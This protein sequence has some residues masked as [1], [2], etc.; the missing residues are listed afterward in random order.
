VYKSSLYSFNASIGGL[1]FQ[2]ASAD[3]AAFTSNVTLLGTGITQVI[4]G[5][6]GIKYYRCIA[7]LACNG[8]TGISNPI[9]ITLNAPLAC[10]CTPP[11]VYGCSDGDVISQVNL[12]TLDNNSGIS[13]PSDPV[14][15]LQGNGQDGNG[16]SDYTG[17]G[18]LTNLQAGT[19]NA[20]GIWVN[21]TNEAIAAWIDYNND[22]V[23]DQST[24]RIGTINTG[25]VQPQTQPTLFFTVPLTA[26]IGIHRLRLRVVYGVAANDITPCSS[27]TYGETEDYLIKIIP[28]SATVNLHLNLQGYYQTNNTMTPT[29]FNEGVSA[30]QTITDEITVELHEAISP[31][32]M[33]YTTNASLLTNG[34]VAATFASLYD[35]N[36]Y[37]AIKHRNS[38][39]TWSANPINI[40]HHSIT[41]LPD[42]IPSNT[43]GGNVVEVGTGIY[44]IYTGDITQDG[45]IDNSDF[46]Q[47]EMDANNFATGYIATDLD[48]LGSA[49][50][51]DFSIW[52]I[53]ANNFVSKIVP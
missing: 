24:E 25:G 22:G 37:V 50:N 33:A 10:Y 11:T 26:T 51:A 21:A 13:C 47:W 27:S 7:T 18:S 42:L 3:N 35:G 5:Q 30:N 44:A 14:P 1:N 17:L 41:N 31:Y 48:G 2:W 53:N 15:G 40:L 39:E 28:A 45:S 16:Y 43:F 32:A 12:N 9:Q 49:D 36:Y 4:N 19:T 29:L 8:T 6:I 52:E 46:S 38:I 20:C 23:F 34:N